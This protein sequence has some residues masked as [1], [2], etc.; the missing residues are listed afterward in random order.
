[1]SITIR[2][3][4]KTD[5]KITQKH[6]WELISWPIIFEIT[7]GRKVIQN[8]PKYQ[9][10]EK[11]PEVWEEIRFCQ[12]L[13][14]NITWMTEVKKKKTQIIHLYSALLW[15]LGKKPSLFLSEINLDVKLIAFSYHHSRRWCTNKMIITVQFILCYYTL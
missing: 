6:S 13:K 5:S 15:K 12:N 11:I 7:S 9:N 1:M 2:H 10:I 3:N 14:E 4:I 8:N